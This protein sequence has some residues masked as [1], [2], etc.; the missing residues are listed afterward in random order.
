MDVKTRAVTRAS[1][2][3]NSDDTTPGSGSGTNQVFMGTYSDGLGYQDISE[4]WF[5]V[6]SDVSG[7]AG[8]FAKWVPASN[9]FYLGDDAA[10]V[11]MGP[12]Q[13][14]SNATLQNSQCVLSAAASS[15]SGAGNILTASFG[16]SFLPGFAGPKS[17]HLYLTGGGGTSGWQLAGTWTPGLP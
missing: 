5:M 15:G 7:V 12:I 10:Q 9:T 3:G 13:G 14:G 2:V 16:L 1:R 6:A 4:A 8:C 11:W 17:T